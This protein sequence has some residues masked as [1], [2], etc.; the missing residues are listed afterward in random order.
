MKKQAIRKA[1]ILLLAAFTIL[2]ACR[3]PLIQPSEVWVTLTVDTAATTEAALQT[4][5][6]L[7]TTV[8]GTNTPQAG[9]GGKCAYVWSTQTLPEISAEV[10]TVFKQAR[11]YQVDVKAEAYGESCIDTT[12][13]TATRFTVIETDFRVTIK[14]ED[15]ENENTL[16]DMLHRILETTFTLPLETYP[17]T[18]LGYMG[19]RFTD[20]GVEKNL[21]FP[22]ETA[23]QA[24]DRRLAG[25][26]LLEAL[27]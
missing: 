11:L 6:A 20:G 10:A 18:R 8:T 16:G 5:S 3:L 1:I 15:L 12:S 27:R 9:I 19:V 22:L 13:N 25:A 7:P 2:V 23:R 26:E 4:L 17:G 24:L 14:V 21:W